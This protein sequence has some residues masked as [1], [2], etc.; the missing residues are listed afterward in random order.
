[1]ASVR[2]ERGAFRFVLYDGVAPGTVRNFVR[3]ADTGFC[4]AR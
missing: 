2:T 3:L 1:V 4:P